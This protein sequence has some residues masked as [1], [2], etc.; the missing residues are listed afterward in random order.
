[1]KQFQCQDRQLCE[2]GTVRIA[3]EVARADAESNFQSITARELELRCDVQKIDPMLERN[4]AARWLGCV[5][6]MIIRQKDILSK[7]DVLQL[8]IDARISLLLGDRFLL[9]VVRELL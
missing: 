4:W 5:R 9:M 6:A 8:H 2:M 3:T 7:R 1:M